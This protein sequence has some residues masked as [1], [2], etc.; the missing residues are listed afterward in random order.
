MAEVTFNKQLTA[1]LVI[2][3]YNDFIS[4][5]GKLWNRL[6]VVAEANNCIP[7][8]LQVL[9]AARKAGLRAA[10]ATPI[11]GRQQHCRAASVGRAEL[12]SLQ[13]R[14]S[15]P[16]RDRLVAQLGTGLRSTR[17]GP[18]RPWNGGHGL[19]HHRQAEFPQ[20][21]H[22]FR[23]ARVGQPLVRDDAVAPHAQRALGRHGRVLLAKRAGG[24]PT[25]KRGQKNIVTQSRRKQT[26]NPRWL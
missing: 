19:G 2:D 6:K 14:R 23:L 24:G 18:D 15:A 25:R 3:P 26:R 7:H 20:G 12:S 17:G 21:S 16:V 13:H 11:R 4:E 1:L 10:G 8:M 5:G 22:G 9:N